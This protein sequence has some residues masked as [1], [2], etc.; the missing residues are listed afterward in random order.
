MHKFT[1][2]KRMEVCRMT[3]HPTSKATNRAGKVAMHVKKVPYFLHPLRIG[4]PGAYY[5]PFDYITPITDSM[6][7]L[8]ERSFGTGTLFLADKE[9]RQQKR[10]RESDSAFFD[11]RNRKVASNYTTKCYNPPLRMG[12]CSNCDNTDRTKL[13]RTGEGTVVCVCGAECA[14]ELSND[15][16]ETHATETSSARADGPCDKHPSEVNS[17]LIPSSAKRKFAL[18]FA[19]EN[20]T[21]ASDRIKLSR[22]NTRKLTAIIESISKLLVQMTPVDHAIA[23]KITIDAEEVFYAS[24]EHYD[25]CKKKNCQKALFNKPASVIAAKSFVNTVEQLSIGN[26]ISGVSRQTITALQER[27]QCSHVFNQRDNATQHHTCL[28]MISELLKNDNQVVC[29]DEPL[30]AA[31][32]SEYVKGVPVQ[33]QLS[34]VHSSPIVQLRDAV[35]HL[36]VECEYSQRVREVAMLALQDGDFASSLTSNHL[37]PKAKGKMACAYILLRSISESM[38]VKA[39]E[40]KNTARHVKNL[41]LCASDILSMTTRMRAALPHRALLSCSDA[42]DDELY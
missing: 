30:E 23:R 22:G 38:N 16:K 18:G 35:A 6:S 8:H 20:A 31:V 1:P 4:I 36:T 32:V 15:Y 34:D 25:R 24:V 3:V 7:A 10:S 41:G 42:D 17:T 39:V 12:L 5:S 9:A 27:V 28:A 40:N 2:L 37:V 19:H 21:K 26:G 14:F 13:R 11:H 29:P 33:R